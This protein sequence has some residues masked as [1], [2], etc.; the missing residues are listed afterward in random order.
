MVTG[1]CWKT[2]TSKQKE[3]TGAGLPFHANLTKNG[4][5]SMNVMLYCRK[6]E[7]LGLQRDETNDLPRI[8]YSMKSPLRNERGSTALCPFEQERK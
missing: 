4:Q 3:V 8:W 7:K 5:D 1:I 6:I 2:S